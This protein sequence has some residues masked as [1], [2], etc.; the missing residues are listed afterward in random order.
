MAY[1]KHQLK[2]THSIY[3]IMQILGISTFDKSAINELLAEYQINQNVNEQLNLFNI[4]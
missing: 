1:I 3:E 2:S 4:N